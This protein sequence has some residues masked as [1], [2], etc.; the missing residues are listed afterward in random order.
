MP[1]LDQTRKHRRMYERRRRALVEK[2]GGQCQSDHCG[3][4]EN[5]EFHHPN[6]RAYDTW[7]LSRWT[8]IAVYEREH[9]LGL[10]ELRCRSCNAK[11]Q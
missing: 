11:E 8:R 7:R 5:L 10:L 3:K 1:S 4:K 2:M 6:G 9:A